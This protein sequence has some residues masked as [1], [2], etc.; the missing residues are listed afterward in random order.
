MS[1]S[2]WKKVDFEKFIDK[3]GTQ[4]IIENAPPILYTKKDKEHEAIFSLIASLFLTGS[5]LI[6][7]ALSALFPIIFIGWILTTTFI[8]VVSVLDIILIYNYIKSNIVIHPIECLFEVFE[9]L[10]IN[11][12]TYYCFQ[13]YP[14]FSGVSHPNEAKDIVY[15]IFQEE[16][17]GNTIQITQ[18]EIYLKINETTREAIILGYHFP[19]GEGI[20]FNNP[21]VNPNVWK[22]FP[23][24]KINGDN[25]ISI[26]NWFHQ[27]EWRFDL[28]LDYDKLDKYAPWVIKRWNKDSIKYISEQDKDK[29]HWEL[30]TV[31]SSPKLNPWKDLEKQTYES[32]LVYEHMQIVE[33][34]IDEI[35]ENEG[36][37]EKYKDIKNL[38]KEFKIYFREKSQ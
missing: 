10:K 22:Y 13:Y 27:Y 31:D 17:L 9:G 4:I 26:A 12:E 34:A 18:I 24:Q 3:F 33:N 28:A 2:V 6:Y 14:V 29:L 25:F 32:P 5:L 35:V 7:I 38:I 1:D 19:Y 21:L 15:K 16:V 37:I 11:S 8:I 36:N 20:A 30:R 23:A